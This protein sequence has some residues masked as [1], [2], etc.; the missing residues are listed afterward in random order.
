MRSE[1][2]DGYWKPVL[3]LAISLG[4]AGPAGVARAQGSSTKPEV[5]EAV[6]PY[7]RGEPKAIE[8]A[9]YVTLAPDL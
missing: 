7:T 4:I 6:D 8:R 3:A 1:G 2:R 9:G 5:L